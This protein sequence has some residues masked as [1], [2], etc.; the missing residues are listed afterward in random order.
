MGWKRSGHDIAYFK[1][2]LYYRNRSRTPFR[3]LTFTYTGG[4]EREAQP[5]LLGPPRKYLIRT[6]KKV[7]EAPYASTTVVALAQINDRCQHS[8][9]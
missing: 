6:I 5:R 4:C 7:M 9:A 8:S 2:S 3:T 1:S